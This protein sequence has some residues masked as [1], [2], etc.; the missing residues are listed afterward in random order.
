MNKIG[1]KVLLL[2]LLFAVALPASIQRT[3]EQGQQIAQKKKEINSQLEMLAKEMAQILGH[4]GFRGFLQSEI[5]KSKNREKILESKSFFEK[6]IG[7]KDPPP[8]LQKL[9]GNDKKTRELIK[10][11]GIWDLEGLDIYFPFEDHR[12]KW[13]GKRDLLVAFSPV[14]DEENVAEII[15]YSVKSGERMILDPE[16]PP[17]TPVLVIAAEEHENHQIEPPLPPTDEGAVKGPKPKDKVKKK[18]GSGNSY[19]GVRYLRIDDDQEPWTKGNP[20]IYAYYIQRGPSATYCQVTYKNLYW[21]N[22]ERSWYNVWYYLARYFDSR[23]SNYSYIR[24]YERDGGTYRTYDV[25]IEGQTCLYSKRDRDDYIA[26]RWRRKSRYGFNYDY[27]QDWGR[28]AVKLR[29]TH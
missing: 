7:Q 15:A 23:Y 4:P 11:S 28:A 1:T 22:K 26:S 21:V 3:E 6:A 8:G 19:F 20:E 27:Y 16:V 24:I 18:D 29:K 10:T 5:A 12:K 9:R 25:T 14:D 17:E 13:K 2:I